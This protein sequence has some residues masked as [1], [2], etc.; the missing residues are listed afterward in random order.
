M[1]F[2]VPSP[3][4][5]TH[6]D[7]KPCVCYIITSGDS[8]RLLRGQL[9][10]M[11]SCGF[12][13]T[14]ITGPAS[15][16]PT[17]RLDAGVSHHVVE[18]RRTIAPLSDL[19][20][21]WALWRLLL[22]I[23][24]HIVN[25]STPK[26][27]LLG[28]IAALLARVPVRIYV[29][30]GLRLETMHGIQRLISTVAEWIASRCANRVVCV[31]PSLRAAYLRL[32]LTS[33]GKAI[34]LGEGSSNGVDLREFPMRGS[35]KANTARRRVRAALGIEG[36]AMVIGCVGRI[37]RDKGLPELIAAF[38]RLNG[39]QPNLHL[40]L[41]GDFETE[42]AG[43]EPLKRLVYGNRRI[44]ITG[45][46]RQPA[47]F[48]A[49]MDLL[50]HPSLR[51]GFPNAVLEA[52]AA[53]LPVIGFRVTGVIDAVVDQ[54]TGRLVEPLDVNDLTHALLQY[55]CSPELIERHGFAAR[56]RV[57]DLFR[58]EIV[59]YNLTRLYQDALGRAFTA[60][61]P[62]PHKKKRFAA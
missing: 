11:V 52:A 31:S 4:S 22:D 34:V 2:R 13:V 56:R 10:Y 23:R 8:L 25:A 37:T 39:Y 41:V 50:V 16:E 61:R 60:Q 14:L 3:P 54:V 38:E 18:M 35:P 55:L 7:D 43:S 9:R 21:L 46:R 32:G 59:L 17:L 1:L 6:A 26:A 27:G 58:R 33:P 24:P 28:M 19:F 12:T 51:E 20:V 29:L 45:F 36:N 15:H 48:F 62:S 42:G 40:L 44:H 30:R 47:P 57:D 53:G 5:C 49:A